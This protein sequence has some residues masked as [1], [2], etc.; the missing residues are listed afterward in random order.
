MKDRVVNI[1]Q[2]SINKSVAFN[3]RTIDKHN[4]DQP[5]AFTTRRELNEVLE[6]FYQLSSSAALQTQEDAIA[7]RIF[8]IGEHIIFEKLLH[9]GNYYYSKQKL[10]IK[11]LDEKE[12]ILRRTNVESASM[13]TRIRSYQL[14]LDG[15]GGSTD[16]YFIERMPQLLD[17]ISF[18]IDKNVSEVF[19]PT[20]YNLLNLHQTI[21]YYFE[22]AH[23]KYHPA[24]D[25]L[26]SRVNLLIDK[27]CNKKE[28]IELMESNLSLSLFHQQFL[29]FNA[30]LADSNF[31]PTINLD[32]DI[33]KISIQQKLR[34]L[35]N[36]AILDKKLFIKHFESILLEYEKMQT[37]RTL[38]AALFIRIAAIYLAETSQTPVELTIN[39]QFD[40]VDITKIL[41]TYYNGIGNIGTV[42]ITPE[43]IA[44]LHSYD[45]N[46]LRKKLAYCIINIPTNEIER[47]MKKTHGVFEISDMELRIKVNG[48]MGYLCMPFK[49]GQEIKSGSVSVDV[50]YQLLRPFF[51]FSNCA[52]VFITAKSCSQSLLNEIKR[53]N[54]KYSFAIDVIEN[55]QLAKL[56]KLMDN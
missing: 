9:F 5:I 1:L 20:L 39:I 56:L 28:I 40:K 22:S 26:L 25:E 12:E 15:I 45:D 34:V 8:K 24:I 36:W 31:T 14:G 42:A 16:D 47:E 49:T 10:I 21:F 41:P 35:I 37:L 43:E 50:F 32:R 48:N 13:L 4:N 7:R 19:Q 54:E 29:Y 11:D 2:D 52:V 18:V 44:L 30:K 3:Y 53:A 23:P 46:T 27:I 55:E 51:H 17:G 6:S 38:D 33:T